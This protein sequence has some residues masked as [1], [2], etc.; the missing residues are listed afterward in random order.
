M[1]PFQ[2]LLWLRSLPHTVLHLTKTDPAHILANGI[3]AGGFLAYHMFYH[4]S[5]SQAYFAFIA[6]IFLTVLAAE[7]APTLAKAHTVTK[8]LFG[9]VGAIAVASA[10]FGLA[11]AAQ[12]GIEQIGA[13]LGISESYTGQAGITAADEEAMLWM[14][15]NTPT[16][17]VFA[18][19]RTS[20][21]PAMSDAISNVYS[22]FS[23]RQAYMEGW[24][25][26]YTNM[27]VSDALL[28]HKQA[29]NA[30]LFGGTLSQE[31]LKQIAEEENIQYLVYAKAW[32]GTPPA[33][34]ELLYENDSVAIYA[35]PTAQNASLA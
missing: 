19:N 10:L 2:F 27:G 25:Y 29:V 17:S 26:T 5:S 3:V 12:P 30:A 4:T 33:G 18:T 32:P 23:Q 8:V 1:M 34:V 16:N 24:M 13:S 20:G 11:A 21:T 22:T 28:A 9:L 7:Q 14:R 35:L 15:E 6:M 31:E